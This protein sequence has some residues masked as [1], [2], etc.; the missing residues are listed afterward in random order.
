MSS[1]EIVVLCGARSPERAVSLRSG[2]ACAEALAKTFAGVRLVVLDENALPPGLDPSRH[3]IFPVIHGDYGEDGRLQAELEARGFAFAGCDSVAS[4]LCI[5]KVATKA[6]L[7][8]AGV[9][10]APEV[11]FPASRRPR[12]RSVA[13]RLGRE[14]VMKPADKG[15]SVGLHMLSG[16]RSLG[17]V[18]SRIR[19]GNWMIEPRLR[20]RELTVGLL[21]G[22]AMGVVEIVPKSGDYDYRSKYTA[23]ATRYLFPAPIPE[24]TAA[25]IRVAAERLFAGCGC[26]DFARADVI[27][28]PSGRFF[29]LEVNTLPG[30]T[31]TSLL[32]K[33]ASCAGLDF[34]ALVRRMIEPALR[35]QEALAGNR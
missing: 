2:A 31:A 29:F 35:R 27:L 6:R 5:D 33:S 8:S 11:A 14:L 34:P 12:A 1:P 17:R 21:D 16:A 30:L 32:P 26:R 20:G 9:P 19:S 7:R 10:V 15:S 18:L 25:A 28:L 13:A 23:G 4:A 24:E 3:V 22:K